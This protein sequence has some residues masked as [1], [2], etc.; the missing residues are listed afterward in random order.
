[1][2]YF[3]DFAPGDREAVGTHAVAA[4]EIVDFAKAWDPQPMHTDPEAARAS[5]FSG[6][7]A[8]GA[9]LVALSVRLLILHPDRA[10]VVA[11]LG[12]DG[13]RFL[14]AVRPGDTLALTR[15]CMEARPS[16]S[17]PGVGIVRNQITFVNQHGRTVLDYTDTILVSRR[18][19]AGED[20]AAAGA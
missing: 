20:G 15:Q 3:E 16:R 19:R 2:K 14:E 18:P 8:S 9:H 17:R 5:A 1:M 6:L 4:E 13:V 7:V 10:A 12:W 11:G